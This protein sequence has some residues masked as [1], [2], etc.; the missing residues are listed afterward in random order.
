MTNMAVAELGRIPMSPNLAATLSRA[1]DYARAQAH[2]EVTLEHLLLALT[3]DQDA[4]LVLTSSNVDPQRL[5]ADVAG[6]LGRIEER[7]TAERQ[8]QLSVSPDLR[9][10]LEAAA[11]AAQQGRRREINGAIVLAAV[12]GDGK[13]T[14]A[15]LLSAHGMTFE[16]AIRALQK[17]NAQAQVT[18]QAAAQVTTPP[19]PAP[20]QATQPPA[21]QPAP[22]DFAP[23]PVQ[24]QPY[25]APQPY[26]QP[27][28]PV[29]AQSVPAPSYAEVPASDVPT[30]GGRA[31]G[32]PPPSMDD[33]LASARERVRM[34]HANAPVEPERHR[35]EPSA[36][37]EDFYD[38]ATDDAAEIP[39]S[40][41]PAYEPDWSTAVEQARPPA[42]PQMPYQPQPPQPQL[43]QQQPQVPRA[44]D[45]MAYPPASP[46]AG[47]APG[48]AL[49]Q[50]MR[51]APSIADAPL[52]PPSLHPHRAMP[53]DRGPR[54]SDVPH[55]SQ[56]QAPAQP[57]PSGWTPPPQ[58]PS[59][60]YP[61]PPSMPGGGPPAMRPRS[62]PPLPPPS[63]AP[64]PSPQPQGAQN[65]PT[66]PPWSLSADARG[67]NDGAQRGQPGPPSNEELS[68]AMRRGAAPSGRPRGM[69]AVEVGQLVENIPRKMQ[70][71]IPTRVEVRIAKADVKALAEG[72]Q[73]GGG[74]ARHDVM[75][76][77][78][79]SVRLRAPDGGFFIE[80]ASPETQWIENTLGLMSDDFASW[81]WTV[82]PRARGT[83]RLQLVVSARTVGADGLAA[84]T[85]L[86]DQ[87]IEVRVSTNFKQAATTGGGWVA[88]AIVGGV[89]AKLGEGAFAS[90][91]RGMGL[92]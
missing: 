73:G 71:A 79:M 83:Q 17:A 75:V 51:P 81:R 47:P 66:P 4:V 18:A 76:T 3:E 90:L 30:T 58:P 59:M 11:A 57:R 55:A 45:P 56:P 12:V 2:V 46:Y 87:V 72:L 15:H 35:A 86:P 29:A 5:N 48:P 25:S 27:E 23:A 24:P 63:A 6:Q 33:L 80:S 88:A 14:A 61:G 38:G 64:R 89:L 19:A 50:S 22:Q 1:T 8:G 62:P 34:R 44:P 92:G 43:A 54:P 31:A 53:P 84:E 68:Q 13:S 67:S 10:I 28:F 69:A 26:A 16:G 91:L 70:V 39:Q 36:E 52:P 82:T 37:P 60:P 7:A 40:D 49:Q 9:R 74:V 20:Q 77:K 21:Q 65:A 85:A 32:S 41:A 78:A 42:P